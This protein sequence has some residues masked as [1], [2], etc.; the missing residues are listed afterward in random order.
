MLYL[1]KTIVINRSLVIQAKGFPSDSV[2]KN[3]SANVEDTSF[4]P[5]SGRSTGKENDS[6]LQYSCMGNPM[7]RG[8]WQVQS[9]RSQRVRHDIVTKQQQEKIWKKKKQ[10]ESMF[11]KA[12]ASSVA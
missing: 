7:D 5:K 12:A 10:T 6:P 2:V 9:M 11:F 1:V 4:V 3:P 8:A